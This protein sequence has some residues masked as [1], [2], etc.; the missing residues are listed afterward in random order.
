MLTVAAW[1]IVGE[2]GDTERLKS[3]DVTPMVRSGMVVP[4]EAEARTWM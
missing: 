1:L 4:V 2:V 3:V